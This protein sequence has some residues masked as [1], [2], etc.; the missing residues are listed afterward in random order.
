MGNLRSLS[1]ASVDAWGDRPLPAGQTGS[2]DTSKEFN[3]LFP[4]GP[5]SG[6]PLH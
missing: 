3:Q 4:Q 2:L 1:F 5:E 6:A